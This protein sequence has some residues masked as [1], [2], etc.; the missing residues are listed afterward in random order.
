MDNY[1]KLYLKTFEVS[2]LLVLF[3]PLFTYSQGLASPKLNI[4][5]KVKSIKETSYDAYVKNGKTCKGEPIEGAQDM[6]YKFDIN[7]NLIEESY[8]SQADNTRFTTVYNY[9]QWNNIIEE[10][11][12]KDSLALTYK[13]SITIKYDKFGNILEFQRNG[14]SPN[15]SWSGIFQINEKG[16]WSELL[17]HFPSNNKWDWKEVRIYDD[18]GNNIA[19]HYYDGLGNFSKS[20]FY[21]YDES[22]LLF[23]EKSKGLSED[24]LKVF[25]KK[26][27]NIEYVSYKKDGS[28]AAKTVWEYDDMSNVV[29]EESFNESGSNGTTQY[30]Y[31]YDNHG[32]WT[33]KVTIN[34]GNPDLIIERKIE[35][36]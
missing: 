32:N 12:Y 33:R 8:Y 7:G 18:N 5:G 20:F 14:K 15:D 17:M 9:D 35:Y 36:Y 29:S 28:L 31:V 23:E 22:G 30:T 19:Q 13:F 3:L 27:N 16:K 26:G 10:Q 11:T 6:V 1:F 24:Y 21:N 2:V 25:D 4:Q 34:D